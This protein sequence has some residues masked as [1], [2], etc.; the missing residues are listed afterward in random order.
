MAFYTEN[1]INEI[2]S[3]I[4]FI[5]DIN[6]KESFKIIKSE[7]YI[8]RNLDRYNIRDEYTKNEIE[9]IRTKANK[10]IDENV[11]WWNL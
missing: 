11:I 8:N 1:S 2:V 7:N 9:K 6:F 3:V 5:F 4:A 10:Y